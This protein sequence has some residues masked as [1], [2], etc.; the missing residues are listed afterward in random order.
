MCIKTAFPT[1]SLSFSFFPF[2]PVLS[3][4][5]SVALTFEHRK[6]KQLRAT[7]AR[8]FPVFDSLVGVVVVSWLTLALLSKSA[9]TE[10]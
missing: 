3:H 4:C 1:S 2:S 9:M 7:R 5:Q 10:S 8:V 6:I